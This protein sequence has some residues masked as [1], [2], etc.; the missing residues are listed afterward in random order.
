MLILSLNGGEEVGI[1]RVE[2]CVLDRL[3]DR[4]GASCLHDSVAVDW[5][6]GPRGGGK[7]VRLNRKL[8]DTL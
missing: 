6:G 5:V 2:P 8:H 4:A 1:V 7:R 3:D